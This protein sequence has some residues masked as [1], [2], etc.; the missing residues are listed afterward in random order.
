MK[1]S[2]FQYFKN[3]Q[4]PD[5]TF[6]NFHVSRFEFFKFPNIHNFEKIIILKTELWNFKKG[7]YIDF[8]TTSKND[9]PYLQT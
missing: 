7:Q 2:N 9:F 8:P 3:F 1:H 4:F 5:F 6:P